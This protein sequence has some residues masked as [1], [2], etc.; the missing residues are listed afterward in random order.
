M[1]EMVM[2]RG[3]SDNELSELKEFTLIILSAKLVDWILES[4]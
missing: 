4:K 2:N 3:Y 1:S